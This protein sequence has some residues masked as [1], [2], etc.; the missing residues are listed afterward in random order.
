[1]NKTLLVVR[2][3]F[4]Q[5]VKRT[6]FIILTLL[7]P[8]IGFL[9]IGIYQIAQNVGGSSDA[10]NPLIG[11]VD[12]LGGFEGYTTQ[13]DITFVPY[14]TRDGA[15][16][17]L[18]ADDIDEYFVIPGDYVSR[19]LITRYTMEQELEVSGTTQWAM[20]VFLQSNLLEGQ[21]AREIAD[22]VKSPMW[23]QSFLLDEKG[24][25]ASEQGGFAAFFAPMVFGFLLVMSIGMTSGF[26]LQGL[27]EEKENR[28]MEVLLSSVSTRQLLTGKVLGL[29]AAGLLQVVIWLAS[30]M[31]LTRLTSE[32]VGGEL[33][34]IQI[35][36][37][38]MIL[39][40]VY[41][42]LGYLFFAVMQA[43]VGAIGSNAK[44][45][46][47]MSVFFILPAILPF[48]IFIIFL[49]ENPDHVLSTIMTM[50]PLTAPMT[51]FL[52]MGLSEIP[53]WELALSISL[54]VVSIVGGL[55]FSAKVFRVFVLMY[56]KSPNLR[57]ILRYL[58]EA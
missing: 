18:L 34:G 28:I 21:T 49:R 56:G 24:D 2:H 7:F 23:L 13:G 1:M 22:R 50:F 9:G 33:A 20:R 32:T 3:E 35:P 55:W 47:Q 25:I 53:A 17:A 44:E 27:G 12:E 29:G 14:E 36:D 42:V 48:Y 19:G 26:L 10:D 38:M 37:N 4:L 39:G 30:M 57:E 51:V 41:F 46:Q 31:V 16:Q 45:S 43:G 58:R 6:S 8:L 15:T 52:R 54:M 11:Y 5:V 40:I